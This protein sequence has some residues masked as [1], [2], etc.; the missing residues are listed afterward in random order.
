VNQLVF[1]QILTGTPFSFHLVGNG[2]L[3][4]EAF[5]TLRPRLVLM[6]L[7]MPEMNGLDATE[8][9]RQFEAY[10]GTHVPV[11]GVTAHA[12]KGDSEKCLAAGMDDYVQKP[13]SPR[14]LMEK[15]EQWMGPV[16]KQERA[17]GL[18]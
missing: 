5:Q 13:I 6:D 11:I 8:E 17:R 12:Q 15:I 2:R 7:S 4:V 1:T 3:A 10:A 18:S 14:V 9:I 16:D